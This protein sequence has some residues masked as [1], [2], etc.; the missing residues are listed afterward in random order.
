MKQAMLLAIGFLAFAGPQ[1][2]AQTT[3]RYKFKEKDKLQ[4]VLDQDT[5]TT[6]SAKGMEAD[7]RYHVI[8]DLDLTVVKVDDAGSATVEIKIT[9][10]RMFVEGPIG[11]AAADS[12]DKN[13][14]EDDVRKAMA[15]T[16]KVMAAMELRGTMLP[17]GEMKN[18]KATAESVKAI[19]ELTGAKKDV[20]LLDSDVARS[21]QFA[22]VFPTGVLA[23]G[24]TWSDKI[25]TKAGY[26]KTIFENTY[27][28]EGPVEKD[29][30]TLDKA[31]IKVSVK[32]EPDEK[33]PAK[34]TIKDVKSNGYL[35]FDNKAGRTIESVINQRT[36]MVVEAKG[37]SANQTIEQTL[38]IRL[39]TK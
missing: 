17:T 20:D 10:A 13:E 8:W 24:K 16:V 27:T 3:L 32:F 36:E 28:Y 34:T 6:V 15:G 5:I 12:D 2:P 29:R 26:G 21:M 4:Y 33:A 30:L 25:V 1:A 9:R 23:K 7:S 38:T 39:K 35:L 14:P 19:K 22:T 18:V 37:V 31:S 11:K